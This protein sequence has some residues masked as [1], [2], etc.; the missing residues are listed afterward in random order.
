MLN[1]ELKFAA[2]I[3]LKWFN[4]KIKSKHLEI[5]PSIKLKYQRE[6]PIDWEEG[7]CAICRFQLSI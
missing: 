4:T 3:L 5:E 2:D 6:N 1:V 7:K